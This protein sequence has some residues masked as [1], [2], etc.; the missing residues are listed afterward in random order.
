MQNKDNL[1]R[2]SEPRRGGVPLGHPALNNTHSSSSSTLAGLFL[3]AIKF[4]QK[5]AESTSVSVFLLHSP[6]VIV[7]TSPCGTFLGGCFLD[8]ALYTLFKRLVFLALSS[9][10]LQNLFVQTKTKEKN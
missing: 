8:L 5:K 3:A 4:I 6:V 10:L 2:E 9:V 1:R 7:R